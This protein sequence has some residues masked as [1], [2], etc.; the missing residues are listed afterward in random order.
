[1]LIVKHMDRIHD[2]TPDN[3]EI[4]KRLGQF[5]N[6]EFGKAKQRIPDPPRQTAALTTEEAP[7]VAPGSPTIPFDM[8]PEELI[9]YLDQFVIG[10]KTAKAVLAT[11]IC[12]HFNRIRHMEET[13]RTD[14]DLVG[15]I[16]S[17][18][19]M[20]GPTGVG[21]TYLIKLIAKKLGV[22]FVKGDATK[23]S[24]TGYVGRDVEDLIREL[25]READDNLRLAE[26]GIVYIDEI[27]K[28]AAS[29]HVS[30]ADISRTGV[31]R[32]LLKPME[33]TEVELKVPHD[34]ISMLQEIDRFQKTGKRTPQVV[35]TRNIL[36][37][38]SGA[39]S[40]LTEIITRRKA[41]GGI[42]FQA[43]TKSTIP[44]DHLLHEVRTEDLVNF[45]LESE[46][47]GRLPVRTVLDPLSL[48]DI[49][50]ILANPNNPILL[51][52]KRDF[53]AYGIDLRLAD[54]ALDHI[55]RQAFCENTG[56]RG[57]V[58]AV[59]AALLPFETALPSSS[60]TKFPV[61]AKTLEDPDAALRILTD[62]AWEKIL[63]ER[64]LVLKEADR[65]RAEAL[66][67]KEGPPLFRRLRIPVTDAR[68]GFAAAKMSDKACTAE[69]AV[70]WIQHEIATIRE[71]EH[72]FFQQTGLNI[73]LEDSGIDALMESA[74][75]GLSEPAT[76]TKELL[77]R[78]E[79][80]LHL[81]ADRT[82]RH[83][84]FISDAAIY[85]PEQ[86]VAGLLRNRYREPE[87]GPAQTLKD[88]H[89]PKDGAK[90]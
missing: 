10:Q 70:T 47:V 38:M 73:I 74:P 82:G 60:V 11:K 89:S 37:I 20:L 53:A 14:A 26:F 15:S 52:K 13:D 66:L 1:M 90:A 77:A 51:G 68:I 29:R 18:I 76:M 87:P 85:D 50:T 62:S 71:A 72:Q 58:S 22:P 44:P 78:L 40:G 8:R 12:T 25:V 35:N 88:P 55:A 64:H 63:S 57:I 6:R 75:H 84:F 7:F 86:Y 16:K 30:G 81:A 83:R 42:G 34:P 80:G 59:E 56:A 41:E 24:E 19:L 36:F 5:L 79:P 9:G 23:F 21:K 69:A 17:N 45:G 49:R 32:A 2:T 27:D 67:T 28:I 54:P 39:F 4:E 65:K 61:D 33:E 48:D 3:R 31:Q 46:F 43:K